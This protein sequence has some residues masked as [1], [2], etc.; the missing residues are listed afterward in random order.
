MAKKPAKKAKIQIATDPGL[1]SHP[2]ALQDK[3]GGLLKKTS[4][5]PFVVFPDLLTHKGK[6]FKFWGREDDGT[7][8]YRE[9]A[10]V[11]TVK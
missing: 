9:P 11:Y 10:F 3:S 8:L 4:I 1:A 6:D 7:L 2:V 5:P